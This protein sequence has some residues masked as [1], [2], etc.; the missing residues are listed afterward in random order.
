MTDTLENLMA[1]REQTGDTKLG[2]HNKKKKKS[3]CQVG[4]FQVKRWCDTSPA[5]E[6]FLCYLVNE[7]M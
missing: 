3:M 5:N 1:V 7:S 6:Q 4:F 2:V